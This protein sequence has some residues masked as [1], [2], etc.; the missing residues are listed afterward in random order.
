MTSKKYRPWNPDQAYVFPPYMRDWLEEE[1]QELL[2]KA[3]AVDQEEDELY[4]KGNQAPC[5][6]ARSHDRVSRRPEPPSP[7]QSPKKADPRHN[8]PIFKDSQS[9]SQ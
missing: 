6:S 4:G 9:E 5:G 1:I 3:E 7:A 8:C 2:T